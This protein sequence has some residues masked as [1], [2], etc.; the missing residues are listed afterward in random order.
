[1]KAQ[2]STEF[3]LVF[4]FLLLV[5][6]IVAAGTFTN[7][8]DMSKTRTD[9]EAVRIANLISS[10]IN[11]AYLEGHGFRTNLT[12]PYT[13]FGKNYT[14]AVSGNRVSLDF[15]SAVF[16]RPLLTQNISGSPLPGPN[17]IENIEGG[18]VI[19]QL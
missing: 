4:M 18:I 15:S 11:T 10:G 5:L 2:A 12:L 17:L 3:I 16:S 7:V 14:A 19:S 13:V 1:M 9:Q 8:L 6:S